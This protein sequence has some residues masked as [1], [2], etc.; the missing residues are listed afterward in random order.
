[1]SKVLVKKTSILAFVT[2]IS[3]VLGFMREIVITNMFGA[4]AA[5]DAFQSANKILTALRGFI[6]IPLSQVFV[7]IL[8][9]YRKT[10]SHKEERALVSAVTGSLGVCLVVFLALFIVTIP[11]WL[12]LALP[13]LETY[14]LELVAYF[15]RITFPYLL[16]IFFCGLGVA[17]MNA[18]DRMWGVALT[19]IWLS[20]ALINAVW[21]LSPYFNTPIKTLG[22]GVLF[23]GLLQVIF[24]IIMLKWIGLLVL[25][26]INWSN[27]EVR[28]IFKRMPPA[29]VGASTPQVNLLV[30]ANL[31]SFLSVGSVTY[32]SVADRLIYFPLSVIG[33]SLST[34]LLKPLSKHYTD[35]NATA[36]NDTLGW[37]LRANVFAALPATII[38]AMLSGPLIITLFL[39][40]Q[41]TT[42]DALKTHHALLGYVVGIPAFMLTKT[43]G[44]ANYAQQDTHTP[45]KIVI[46]G[47]LTTVILGILFIPTLQQ[48]G[49]TLA[50]SIS[51]WIQ[52][53]LLMLGLKRPIKSLFTPSE[54][55][56]RWI[57]SLLS[58]SIALITFVYFASPSLER[59]LEWNQMYRV[60]RLLI[61]GVGIS[62]IVRIAMIFNTDLKSQPDK[63]S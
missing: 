6:E 14:R 49:I 60:I 33:I 55:F 45:M 41:F 36:F 38:I 51:A 11:Y 8:S 29:I 61:L 31:A 39:H 37:G 34:A 13:G 35:N 1:M 17:I 27:P 5:V 25:P 47:A 2:L 59:W 40:G 4:S 48:A 63:I 44:S 24:V 53:I 57:L 23:G 26:T 46:V 7:P 22:W 21:W 18:Y 28:K 54:G 9:E 42:L 50:N 3:R 62:I 12:R 30:N 56:R 52:V 20:I 16:L 15:L 10:H 32:I 19:P 58:M 43:L